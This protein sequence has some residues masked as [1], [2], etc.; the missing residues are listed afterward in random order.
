MG[1]AMGGPLGAILGFAFASVIDT[2]K[3]DVLKDQKRSTAGDFI[4]SLLVLVAAVMKADGKVVKSELDYVKKYFIQAFGQESATEAIKMLRDILQRDIPV[5]EVCRQISTHMDYASRLQLMHFLYGIA[6]A[7]GKIDSTEQK[8]IDEISYYLGIKSTDSN[9]IKSMF[10]KT[11]DWAYK[12]LEITEKAT[13]DEVKK[14]YRRMANKYHPDKVAY[15]GE[16][17]K[18]KAN[19]KFRKINEAYNTIKKERGVH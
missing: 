11:T 2:T 16:E 8:L 1:F 3:F 19:E 15:L 4:A 9:S 10:V 12:V 17:I 14:A 6:D 13:D 7:D 18:A 5:R